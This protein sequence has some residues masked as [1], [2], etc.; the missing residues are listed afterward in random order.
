MSNIKCLPCA[1]YSLYLNST[2]V[3]SLHDILITASVDSITHKAG[4]SQLHL[5]V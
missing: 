5:D 1:L 4:L 2:K 3:M